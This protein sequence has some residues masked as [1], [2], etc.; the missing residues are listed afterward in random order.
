[1]SKKQKTIHFNV[2]NVKKLIENI[3]IENS[4]YY[5][6]VTIYFMQDTLLFP[7]KPK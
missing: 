3:P 5:S 2:D 4:Q 6:T 7:N 1:M